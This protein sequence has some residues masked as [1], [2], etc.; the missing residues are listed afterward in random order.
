MKPYVICDMVTSV[1]GRILSSRW[2]PAGAGGGLFE[3]LHERL[4]DDA[5]LIGSVAGQQYAKAEAYPDQ[6]GQ[7]YP[8]EP[9]FA[10]RG[11]APLS[12]SER[13]TRSRARGPRQ[14]PSWVSNPA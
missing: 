13:L 7:V 2:W 10:W 1:D 3:H 11:L 5:R 8:S 9:W 12:T 14:V 4:G 6:I